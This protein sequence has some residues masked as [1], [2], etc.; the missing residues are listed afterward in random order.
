ME[1]IGVVI[2]GGKC[3]DS[4]YYATELRNSIENANE[5]AQDLRLAF[6]FRHEE[7]RSESTA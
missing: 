1:P 4:T 7:L 6:R 2:I 3:P 5:T